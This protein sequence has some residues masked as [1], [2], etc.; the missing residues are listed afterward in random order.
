MSKRNN[1]VDASANKRAKLDNAESAPEDSDDFQ[2][3]EDDG[4]SG[5]TPL[6]RKGNPL[7]VA[8]LS[9]HILVEK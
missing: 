8:S 5:L 9:T 1:E 6:E 3:S 2:G 4:K 7:N